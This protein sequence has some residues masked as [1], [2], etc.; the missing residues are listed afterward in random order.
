MY[1]WIPKNWTNVAIWRLV[2][3]L[4]YNINFIIFRADCFGT[5]I[6][7][8]CMEALLVKDEL[9]SEMANYLEDAHSGKNLETDTKKNITGQE[10]DQ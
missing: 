9:K 4:D 5:K 7:Y 10:K 6:F 3:T 8:G 2:H 1:F